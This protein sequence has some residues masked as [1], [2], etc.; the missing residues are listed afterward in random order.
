MTSMYEVA[1]SADSVVRNEDNVV[2]LPSGHSLVPQRQSLDSAARVT[3]GAS[4]F[5]E[6]AMSEPLAELAVA[7]FAG[8]R[9]KLAR[10]IL[11]DTSS[12]I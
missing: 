3:T 8:S 1:L 7:G 4:G 6:P 2:Q 5:P 11:K 9:V 10:H 12:L